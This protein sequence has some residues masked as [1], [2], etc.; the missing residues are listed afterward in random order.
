[1]KN[2]VFSNDYSVTAV[3]AP[4]LLTKTHSEASAVTLKWTKGE[5]MEGIKHQFIIALKSQGKEPLAIQTKECFKTISNL[6]PGT[7]YTIEV[8]TMLIDRCSE[9]VSTTILTGEGLYPLLLF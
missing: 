6:E 3:S 8:S 2:N 1:M 9:P 5:N 7:E 4:R